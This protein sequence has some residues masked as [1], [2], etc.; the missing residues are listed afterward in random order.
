[1]NETTYKVLRPE[2]VAAAYAMLPEHCAGGVIRYFEKR[3]PPGGFLTAVLCND[4]K[5]SFNRADE[6]NRARLYD[7][8]VWLYTYAPSGAYGSPERVNAWLYPPRPSA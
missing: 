5:E 7:Y 6:I 4:L 3:V 1:M 2:A 8:A